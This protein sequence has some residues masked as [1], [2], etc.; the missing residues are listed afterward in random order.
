[1]KETNYTKISVSFTKDDFSIKFNAENKEEDSWMKTFNWKDIIRICLKS[2]D[3]GASH[4]LYLEIS[5]IKEDIIVP[6]T[7][8]GGEAFLT[9]IIKRGM[10]TQ[11]Q[12]DIALARLGSMNIECWPDRH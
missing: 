4:F 1:M 10:I 7:E 5:N 3:Y 9:E 6:I 2:Y 8:T 12:I 11:N